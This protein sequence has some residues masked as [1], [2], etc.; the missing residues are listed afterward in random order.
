MIIDM[1]LMRVLLLLII[2]IFAQPVA[3]QL[4]TDFLESQT[5]LSITPDFPRPG[6][7][8]NISFANYNSQLYGADIIWR[9]NGE[10]VA[11]ASNQKEVEFIAGDL[12]D[13]DVVSVSVIRDSRVIQSYSIDVRP[14]YVDIILEP[15]TRTPDFYK[16]RA[17]PSVGSQINATVLV[18]NSK[19]LTGDYIYT[20]RIGNRVLEG[21]PIRGT[22]K[23]SFDTPRGSKSTLTVDV[24]DTNGNSV[25]RRAIYFRSSK[26]ELV[27]YESN[28]LY[29]Q[30]HTAISDSLVL[31]GT[32]AT[33]I[34]EPYHLDIRTYNNPDVNEWEIDRNEQANTNPNP[35]QITIQ[36]VSEGGTSNVSF[37][38]RSTTE[39]LQGAQDSIQI[40]F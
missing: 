31:I 29:G 40:V 24:S 30:S 14:T 34:A 28:A 7:L 36:K 11:D 19:L 8:T 22:N 33:I 13:T 5:N 15:Q 10:V 4:D 32:A 16:G 17:S 1:N 21:G 6:Q 3:A 39:F 23:V 20:W 37:H 35:Y 18:N 12:G 38:V 27:F 25:G 2:V 26:P 9:L